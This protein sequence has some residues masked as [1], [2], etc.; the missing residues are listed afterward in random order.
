MK[1]ALAI[2]VIAL[3]AI[4]MGMSVVAPMISEATMIPEAEARHGYDLW[5]R[6]CD[7]LR[8]IPNPYPIIEEMIEDHCNNF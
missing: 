6:A 1:R 7:T 4:V 3:V 5:P 2:S 8:S